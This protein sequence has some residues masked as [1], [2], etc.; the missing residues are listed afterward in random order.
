MEKIYKISKFDG[1][2]KFLSAGYFCKI[3]Y[4]DNEYRS[5]LHA[6]L[7]EIMTNE[8]DRKDV[9]EC[10]TSYEALKL[11]S[12]LNTRKDIDLVDLR[13]SLQR[14]KFTKSIH[15]RRF[16]MATGKDILENGNYASD[17]FWGVDLETGRGENHDGKILMKIRKELFN[18]MK[19][20]KRQKFEPKR[21][22]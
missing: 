10:N 19:E 16:L 6:F 3:T 21:M 12:T 11:S 17:D 13:E 1:L 15:L 2:Y 4:N 22:I 18:E 7:A 20:K 9:S 5:V 14:I 8:K